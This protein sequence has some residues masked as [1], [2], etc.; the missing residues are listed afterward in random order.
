MGRALQAMGT[1]CSLGNGVE[2]LV[3]L[4][5][6]EVAGEIRLWNLEKDRGGGRWNELIW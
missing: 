2:V 5:V 4:N 3:C 1:P 6:L